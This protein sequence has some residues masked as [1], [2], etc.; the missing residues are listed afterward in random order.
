MR[1]GKSLINSFIVVTCNVTGG[2]VSRGDFSLSLLLELLKTLG[3]TENDTEL[4][5]Y[6]KKESKALHYFFP[7]IIN[8]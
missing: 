1:K 2:L 6:Q 3:T 8:E 4:Y 5:R 7:K